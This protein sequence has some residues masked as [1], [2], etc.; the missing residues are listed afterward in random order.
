MSEENQSVVVHLDNSLR[1]RV[2][3]I[4]GVLGTIL[5]IVSAFLYLRAAEESAAEDGAINAPAPQ[6]AVKLG[7]SLLGIIRAITDWAR[8]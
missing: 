7:L 3:I 2:L 8:R 1:A 5:G 4:G 6:D